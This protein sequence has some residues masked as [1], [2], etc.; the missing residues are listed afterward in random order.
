M[1]GMSPMKRMQ[2]RSP[3]NV[4][5][6]VGSGNPDCFGGNPQGNDSGGQGDPD[7]T[8]PCPGGGGGGGNPEP[9]RRYFRAKA[10]ATAYPTLSSNKE[11]DTWYEN[12]III[13]RAQGFYK[14]FNTDY[15]PMN[16]E[17]FNSYG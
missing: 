12:L 15:V 11:F 8:D 10:D 5:G 17:Y 7:G 13:A 16:T 1:H 6:P 2:G 9:E 4:E 3:N 14:V